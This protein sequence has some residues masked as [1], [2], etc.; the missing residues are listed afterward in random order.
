MHMSVLCSQGGPWKTLKRNV[1]GFHRGVSNLAVREMFQRFL[2]MR[3][4]GTSKEVN[5]VVGSRVV[6]T[7]KLLNDFL[8]F[9]EV[10]R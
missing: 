1:L 6:S 8:F 5:V 10:E 9:L 4:K 3:K 2:S 7:A